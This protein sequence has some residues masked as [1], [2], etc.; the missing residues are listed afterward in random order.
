MLK[1]LQ[2]ETS[3][4]WV[5]LL[6]YFAE[7]LTNKKEFNQQISDIWQDIE[8]FFATKIMNFSDGN[9]NFNQLNTW[10][11]WQTETHRLIRLLKTDLIFFAGAKQEVTKN[12]RLASIQEKL[13]LA[14]QLTEDLPKSLD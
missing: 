7:E 5:N 9:F 12:I 6:K 1:D 10:Q 13:K 11:Q 8:S 3:E 4:T 2:K 14:I